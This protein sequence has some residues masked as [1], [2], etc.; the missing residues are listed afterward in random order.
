MEINNYFCWPCSITW[1][2]VL[3]KLWGLGIV[4]ILDLLFRRSHSTFRFSKIT[5]VNSLFFKI[6]SLTP[7]KLT[8]FLFIM[9]WSCLD[10]FLYQKARYMK[11]LSINFLL[12][13]AAYCWLWL[14]ERFISFLCQMRLSS[15]MVILAL[16]HDAYFFLTIRIF[17]FLQQVLTIQCTVN[18]C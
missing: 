1:L 2:T 10:S 14:N 15:R 17:G 7:K 3:K 18:I 6:D 5:S 9:F 8:R 11:S 13:Q 12:A 4:N 16:H